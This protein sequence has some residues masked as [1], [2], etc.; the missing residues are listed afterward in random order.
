MLLG[1]PLAYKKYIGI[2]AFH[3]ALQFTFSTVV[4]FLHS[5]HFEV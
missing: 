5:L 1:I 2:H 4:L 3:I